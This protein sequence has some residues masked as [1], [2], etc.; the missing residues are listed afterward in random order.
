MVIRRKKQKQCTQEE[1]N[2][3]DCWI[4]L[5]LAR[6]SGLILAACVGKHTDVFIEQLVV[7][8][9]GKTDCK[10]F[11]TDD[12]GDMSECCRQRSNITLAK[13]KHSDWNGRMEQFG[14]KR[15]DGIGDRISLAKSGNKQR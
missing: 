8:T 15:E 3:G 5:S 13:I 7:N 9:E 12:W 14:N 11:N 2:R 6:L 4:G 10:Q 1:L